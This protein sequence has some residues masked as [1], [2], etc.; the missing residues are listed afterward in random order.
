MTQKKSSEIIPWVNIDPLLMEIAS[1]E[2]AYK[3][4]IF[5]LSGLFSSGDMNRRIHEM[6]KEDIRKAKRKF[7]KMW[8]KIVQAHIKQTADDLIKASDA[9]F[10]LGFGEK[11]PKDYHAVSR[12]V[13]VHWELRRRARRRILG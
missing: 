13:V 12:K 9:A 8:R 6:S 10:R 4:G 3:S 1:A 7:R 11:T 5:P 2:E